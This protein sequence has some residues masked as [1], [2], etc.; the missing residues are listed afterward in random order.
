M[1]G[2][3]SFLDTDAATPEISVEQDLEEANTSREFSKSTPVTSGSNTTNTNPSVGKFTQIT[4][5]WPVSVHDSHIFKTSS[6]CKHLEENHKGLVDGVL[7]GDNGY[8]CRPFLLTPYNNPQEPHQERFNGS[9]VSTRS[10]IERTFGVWKKRFH[11][12]HSEIRMRP[13]RSCKFIVACAILYNIAMMLKEPIIANDDIS[14]EQPMIQPYIGQQDG[15][16]IRNHN[17]TFF[18]S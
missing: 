11:V 14:E 6:I 8:M 7:L 15:R 2:V 13:D 4:A 12:L 10:L 3:D 1:T 16:G 18:F 17:T 5:D 9:H